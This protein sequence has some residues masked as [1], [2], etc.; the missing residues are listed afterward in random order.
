[1]TS[2]IVAVFIAIATALILAVVALAKAL[3]AKSSADRAHERIDALL[4][5]RE[6]GARFGITQSTV[7]KI[8]RRTTYV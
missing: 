2:Y 1:M 8:V 6:I 7:S 4:L 3:A 5:Q